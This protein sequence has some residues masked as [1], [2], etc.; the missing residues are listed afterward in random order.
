MN[1]QQKDNKLMKIVKTLLIS[2]AAIL[3]ASCA[4]THLCPLGSDECNSFSDTYDAAKNGVE[5]EGSRVTIFGGNGTFE[6][7]FKSAQKDRVKTQ[8][9]IQYKPAMVNNIPKNLPQGMP[10][11]K[12]GTVWRFWVA[13]WRSMDKNG[14]EILHSGELIYFTTEGSFSIGNLSPRDN[15]DILKPADPR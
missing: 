3:S 1:N 2:S 7:D 10:V 14:D 6:D 4:T 9:K 12:P 13:P 11:Y 8:S 15:R 5:Q